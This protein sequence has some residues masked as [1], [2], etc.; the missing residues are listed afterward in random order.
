MYEN[1][2]TTCTNKR[3]WWRFYVGIIAQTETNIQYILIGYAHT[4][5]HSDRM[6]L[7]HLRIRTE[8]R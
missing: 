6:S 2:S 4:D 5:T 8:Q 1:S 3:L 7:C